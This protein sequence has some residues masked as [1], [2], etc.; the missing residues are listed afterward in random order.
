M[1]VTRRS[2]RL[3]RFHDIVFVALF[4]LA[5][6]LVAW[7]S[8]RYVY[9][10]DWTAS[11]RNTLSEA[12]AA[13]LDRLPGG[14]SITV[15]ARETPLRRHITELVQR[16][17]RLKPDLELRFVN[18]DLEPELARELDIM[19][20]G[21]MVIEY[22][23]RS[24]RL[25]D[26]SES[27]L[28]NALQRVARGA[29]RTLAFV[30]GHGERDPQGD[31]AHDYSGWAQALRARGIAVTRINLLE[32]Q[33]VPAS[34]VLVVASPRVALLPGEV[35]R[36]VAHVER[37]GNLLWLH[38]PGPLRGLDP[39]A[40]ALGVVVEDGVVVDPNVSRVGLLLFGTDDP[41]VALVGRYPVHDVTRDFGF[42]TL[43]P[44]AGGLGSR[45]GLSWHATTLLETLSNTWLERG[46][47][48]GTVVFD[49]ESDLPGPVTIGMALE[50]D[51]AAA[52]GDD[53]EGTREAG[54]AG[55]R[56]TQRAMVIADGDF[57]S[58]GFLGL[59]GNLQL[60]L[61]VVN[62]LT[63]D[64]RLI[65]VPARIAPDTALELS[66]LAMGVIGFGFLIGLPLLLLG[67][68]LTVWFRR[69]RR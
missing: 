29:E 17:Q 68:G 55:A 9:E 3:L 41:R 32:T 12:S 62:W 64:D 2:K 48:S 15:Y 44:V 13:L 10:T 6:G 26:V 42:N 56:G 5:I 52:A 65:D 45:D 38:D 11:G 34:T 43:F 22:E 30:T 36:I 23:G 31:A 61:N 40:D 51:P 57:A 66:P 47:V 20:D 25:R 63:G 39:L 60:A 28:T 14:V 21:E 27:A 33:E 16:Y 18:P 46:E 7:L 53:V 67:T 54:D 24:E 35:E 58:N 1:E 49:E 69:R 8:T 50:R 59:G 37:G 4:L 19:M